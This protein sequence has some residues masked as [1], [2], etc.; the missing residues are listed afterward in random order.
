VAPDILIRPETPADV[1]GIWRV[2]KRAF[3]GTSYSDGNEQD[4]VDAL[5]QRGAL[6]ISLVAEQRGTILGHVAFSPASSEDG[7]PDWYTLGPVSVDP[8]VQRCGIGKALI[9]TGIARLRELR[10]AGCIVLGDTRYYSQFGFSKA[11]HMAPAGVPKEHFMVLCLGPET[12]E[13]VVNFH[14]VFHQEG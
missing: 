8:D 13:C 4:I 5:R 6:A 3:A 1:T 14:E 11:P 2:T 7:A 9:N 12:P 10:A